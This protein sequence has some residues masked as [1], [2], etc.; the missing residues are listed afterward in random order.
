MVPAGW[1]GR[2]PLQQESRS[3]AFLSGPVD[4]SLA[5]EACLNDLD[6][7]CA[8]RWW[9][10]ADLAD[11]SW[12]PRFVSRTLSHGGSWA[13]EA[14]CHPHQSVA[15]RPDRVDHWAPPGGR[16]K[17]GANP[18]RAQTE[19]TRSPPTNR[20]QRGVSSRRRTASVSLRPTKYI[21]G[22]IRKVNAE[23]GVR[24]ARL[25]AQTPVNLIARADQE[26][27]VVWLWF[28]VCLASGSLDFTPRIG[29]PS[30]ALGRAPRAPRAAATAPEPDQSRPSFW[31]PPAPLQK[32][33]RFTI[34]LPQSDLDLVMGRG[35]ERRAEAQVAF[36]FSE[37]ALFGSG[38]GKR[39]M[40]SLRA[41][42]ILVSS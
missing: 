7:P 13:V 25:L 42:R 9:A 40:D 17:G 22:D 20:T 2:W 10:A 34:S 41:R 15:R 1:L 32:N 21:R 26:L 30:L 38:R 27:P 31:P 16:L 29:L 12:T 37:A 8:A 24:L 35:T 28:L 23:Q 39:Q 14:T 33:C 19:P 4:Q 36:F 5:A 11:C 18:R 3:G 6:L